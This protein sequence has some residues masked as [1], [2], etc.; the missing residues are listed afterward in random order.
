MER[1]APISALERAIRPLHLWSRGQRG[2][3]IRRTVIQPLDNCLTQL[4]GNKHT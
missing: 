1:L 2:Q 3:L 4:L